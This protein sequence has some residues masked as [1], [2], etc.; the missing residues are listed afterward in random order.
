[1]GPGVGGKGTVDL[2]EGAAAVGRAPAARESARARAAA[3]SEPSC[4]H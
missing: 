3:A 4:S 2:A 1:M